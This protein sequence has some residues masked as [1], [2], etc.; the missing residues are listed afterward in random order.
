MSN[1]SQSHIYETSKR[2]QFYTLRQAV[3]KVKHRK[4][5]QLCAFEYGI[6]YA[7]SDI[8][9]QKMTMFAL[10]NLFDAVKNS[11]EPAKTETRVSR[12]VR[13]KSIRKH[14]SAVKAA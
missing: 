3:R 14:I 7:L 9:M 2:H 8:R 12:Y 4:A 10:V 1:N 6:L 13:A 11:L 5:S